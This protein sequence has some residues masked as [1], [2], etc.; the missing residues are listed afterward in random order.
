MAEIAEKAEGLITAVKAVSS[1]ASHDKNKV[2][3]LS[4]YA[5]NCAS[6]TVGSE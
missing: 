3:G 4:E 6:A 1:H 5:T 2:F